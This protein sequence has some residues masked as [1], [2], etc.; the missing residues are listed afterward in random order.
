MSMLE[1]NRQSTTTAKVKDFAPDKSVIL[2]FP[3]AILAFDD[4]NVHLT[5]DVINEVR[6]VAANGRGEYRANAKEF[7]ILL[8]TLLRNENA[9]KGLKLDNGG[10]L[11]IHPDSGISPA[12]LVSK[13]PE[14]ILVTR[15]P[16]ERVFAKVHGIPCEDYK[17]EQTPIDSQSYDGRSIIY[18]PTDEMKQFA[19]EKILPVPKKRSFVAVKADGSTIISQHFLTPNEYLILTDSSNPKHTMLGRYDGV[20][21]AIVPLRYYPG[22][23]VG[24]VY[25][26][27]PR[28]VG[29]IFALDALLAPPSVAPLVILKGPAGTAKTFLSMA[30]ALAQ[31]VDDWGGD[32][33]FHYKKILL[34]R[35]NTKMDD[36]IGY[37]K[38]GE[39]EKILPTLRGLIDNI[40]NLSPDADEGHIKDGVQCGGIVDELLARGVIDAQAMAYMRGRSIM[41]QYIVCDEMQNA[42]INQV[43][44]IVTRV[45]EESKIVLL[46]D[47]NQIDHLLLDK[48]T[49]G[50]SYAADRMRGSNLTFQ[51]T[52]DESECTRSPLAAE[53]IARLTPK[54][55]S[56]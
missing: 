45:A 47:P 31:T 40:I 5:Y 36:D 39:H 52:F 4:N 17:S 9:A 30:A 34:T 3:I 46:G 22:K 43:L 8:D 15:D 1:D 25:G 20:A 50:I 13:N 32:E 41:R 54:G 14:Y 2:S 38:G 53:A 42:T 35:P 6:D 19:K 7:G 48:R 12:K 33:G 10:K 11:F 28:N 27:T 44:S 18:I 29:Q 24:P 21:K 55:A 49:N 16:Y 26:V 37:L 51:I 23:D 56:I